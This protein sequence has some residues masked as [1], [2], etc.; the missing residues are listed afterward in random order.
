MTA[1][2]AADFFLSC[3]WG[4]SAF[5]LRLVQR[6]HLRVKAEY[7]TAEGVQTVSPAR[8]GAA[9]RRAFLRILRRGLAALGMAQRPEIP[10]II[11]GMATSNLGWH[12][13][14]YART[15]VRIDGRDF[16]IADKRL[17]GRRV[18]FVSGLCTSDDVM[19][20]EE[21]ELA[22]LFHS[23][24]RRIL[25]SN[26]VVVLTGTHAKHVRL[27]RDAIAGFRT[28]PTGELFAL[29]SR[30]STLCGRVSRGFSRSAFLEG[31]NAAKTLGLGATLF[32]TRA[33]V[34]LGRLRP[35]QAADFLSGA[36]IA[37]ELASL[38][39]IG[40]VVLAAGP[41]LAERYRLALRTMRRGRK[42]TVVAPGRVK[43]AVVAGH[44]RLLPIP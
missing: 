33:R 3:D 15:P 5:R 31:V 13:M 7:A 11:S 24:A 40:R 14:P 1:V 44:A 30:H 19:R 9:R 32:Q 18:R 28:H 20:G 2:K 35:A 37:A 43:H 38:P 41:A 21:V 25:A 29:L 17:A 6:R 22:G 8:T 34:V 39:R 36:L 12:P 27:R 4:T 23:S 42:I 26:C 10:L 16:R